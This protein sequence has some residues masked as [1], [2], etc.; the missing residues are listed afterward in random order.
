MYKLPRFVSESVTRRC[1]TKSLVFAFLLLNIFLYVVY[2]NRSLY[3]HRMSSNSPLIAE[4]SLP[5]AKSEEVRRYIQEVRSFW[6]PWA[7]VIVAAKPTVKV[8]VNGQ[9]GGNGFALVPDGK[10]TAPRP[11]AQRL[12]SLSADEIKNLT[13]AHQ[14]VRSALDAYVHQIHEVG[15]FYGKGVVIP[16][17]GR[18]LPPAVVNIHMLR[19]SGSKLPVEV[20][21]AN[22]AEYN[23][24]I[25][26][27]VLP[28]LYARCLVLSDFVRDGPFETIGH[29]QLKVMTLMFSNFQEVVFLDSDIVPLI[30]PGILLED[31]AYIATGFLGWPDYWVGSESP[32]FYT[33]AGRKQFPSNL[34][35]SSGESGQLVVDKK[36]HLKTLILATYYNFYG[37]GL[38]YELQSQGAIGQGDKTT[39]ETAAYVLDLPWYR[40][41]TPPKNVVRDTGRRGWRHAAS[42]QHVPSKFQD[43]VVPWANVASTGERVSIAFLHAN[44]PKMNAGELVH[45]EQLTNEKGDHIR[46]WGTIERQQRDLGQDVERIVWDAL[47]ESACDIQDFIKEWNH[48]DGK[49]TC[50]LLKEH[51]QIVFG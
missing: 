32:D 42:A 41:P 21:F 35:Y 25:C 17:G 20:W 9:Y 49:D 12:V 8:K 26:D 18:Y 47:V 13:E 27:R 1:P 31:E 16:A 19:A 38:F 5:R 6:E 39:Y 43:D 22:W 36:R 29:Y 10:L 3:I 45:G 34:P 40:I 46:I 33:I 23:E 30:D 28:H 50:T 37:P 44:N 4:K 48:K 7:E 51:Q 11:P 15:L 14:K 24:E 2:T